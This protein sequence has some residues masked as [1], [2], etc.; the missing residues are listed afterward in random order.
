M[1]EHSWSCL[2]LWRQHKGPGG[3]A[4][5]ALVPGEAAAATEHKVA[6]DDLPLTHEGEARGQAGV[7]V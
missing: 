5:P 6:L 2:V 1:L 3:A 4:T 7:S